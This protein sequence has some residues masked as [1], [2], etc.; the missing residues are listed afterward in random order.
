V[1]YARIE[2]YNPDTNTWTN[3]GLLPSKRSGHSATLMADGR[4][5]L[6]GGSNDSSILDE[7][8]V[9]DPAAAIITRNSLMTHART[10]HKAVLLPNGRVMILGGNATSSAF[11]KTT[12]YYIG[13]SIFSPSWQPQISTVSNAVLG[14]ALTVTG[15]QFYGH[16]LSEAGSGG[17]QSVPSGYPFLL[18]YSLGNEQVQWLSPNPDI[19]FSSNAF[20]SLPLADFP[21]G[22]AYVLI[23]SNGIPSDPWY[24]SVESKVIENEGYFIYLPAVIR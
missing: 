15:N 2:R 1:Y 11:L 4:V 3:L 9:F 12:E 18:L 16:Q 17:T 8:L 20:T 19:G 23:F 7:Y 14:E 6:A 22:P 5:L 13:S 21:V 24:A 10:E